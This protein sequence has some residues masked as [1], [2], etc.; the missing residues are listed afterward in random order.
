MPTLVDL[1]RFLQYE[2]KIR[3]EGFDKKLHDSLWNALLA[4]NMKTE[5]KLLVAV[6]LSTFD[7]PDKSFE[8][9]LFGFFNSLRLIRGFFTT[10]IL[11]VWTLHNFKSFSKFL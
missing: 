6:V 11:P 2:D 5:T 7:K 1:L 3:H 8:T 10:Q 4:M 9:V